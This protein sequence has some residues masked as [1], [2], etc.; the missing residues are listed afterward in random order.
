MARTH[1]IPLTTQKAG[2]TKGKRS[3][4][5]DT[6]N[7]VEVAQPPPG[8][9][10]KTAVSKSKQQ[11]KADNPPTS[12][13]D[14]V[15]TTR[16]TR[17]R[18]EPKQP[19]PE[20]QVQHSDQ[21]HIAKPAG[22][23]KRKRRTREEIAADKAKAEAEKKRQEE[24]TK[25]NHHIMAKMDIDK[26]IDRA[27]TAIRTIRTF[28]EIEDESGEEFIGYAAIEDSESELDGGAE[29][30]LTLKE[31]NKALQQQIK[32]LKAQVDSGKKKGKGGKK[33]SQKVTFASGLLPDWNLEA[34]LIK[35][36]V[37]KQMHVQILAGGLE[38]SDAEGVNLFPPSS[39]P[40]PHTLT[41]EELTKGAQ[42][43][44]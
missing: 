40:G 6:L 12:E 14:Q 41:E 1:D 42:Q 2:A 7:V 3:L 19:K 24:L 21:A 9:K 8:K 18:K 17:T 35:E 28:A 30:A 11:V 33:T 22:P 32:A 4:E 13:P 15:V 26:D 29:D 39:K 44:K 43:A 20:A 25:E 37:K 27:E 31:T 16:T 34:D 36:P 10:A 23:Q 38:D 5:V